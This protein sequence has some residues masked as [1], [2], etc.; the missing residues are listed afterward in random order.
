VTSTG[1][2]HVAVT[3]DG[4][5]ATARLTGEFDMSATF[6]VEPALERAL[7][8]PGI[9]ALTVDLSQLSFI[10]ST[11][12]GVLLRLNSEAQESGT[13]LAIVPA[14]PQVQ[15]IFEVAGVSEALPF[16]TPSE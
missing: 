6:N 13:E 9:R 3:R 16:T 5:H 15:R 2:E 1:N 12:I 7:A 11:G 10:D 4:D 14:E 8:Q